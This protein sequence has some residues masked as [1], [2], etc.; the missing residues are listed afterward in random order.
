MGI[1]EKFKQWICSHTGRITRTKIGKGCIVY[2]THCTDCGKAVPSHSNSNMTY[3]EQIK[4]LD[5]A[6][7]TQLRDQ[8]ITKIKG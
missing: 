7:K 5:L 2:E 3:D 1:K 6:N 8:F 4:M